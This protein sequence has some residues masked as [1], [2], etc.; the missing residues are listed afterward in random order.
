L[1]VAARRVRRAPA[2]LAPV[3]DRRKTRV[4]RDRVL[5][6][7][8]ERFAKTPSSASGAETRSRWARKYFHCQN[9]RLRVRASRC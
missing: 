3:I 9:S 2:P 4:K 6:I 5:R 8:A 1:I 7:D